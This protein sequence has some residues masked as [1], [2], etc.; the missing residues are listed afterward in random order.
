MLHTSRFVSDRNHR[1]TG[2][3]RPSVSGGGF[4]PASGC[5]GSDA[6][7]IFLYEYT[8]AVGD[9][10][11]EMSAPLRAE[12]W[13]MLRALFQDFQAIPGME[14]VTLL[15]PGRG[16]QRGA[17]PQAPGGGPYRDA[18]SRQRHRAINEEKSFRRLAG[19]A[20]YSLVIAPETDELLFNRCQ[21]V[22]EGGGTLLGPSAA[23]VQLTGDKLALGDRLRQHNIRTPSC[24]QQAS[25]EPPFPLPV[26]CKPR[27][28]AGSLHTTL[29]RT[30]EEWLEQALPEG[31]ERIV[32]PFVPGLAASVAFL[33]GPRQTV[34]LIP[35]TQELSEDGQFHYLGGRMPLAAPLAERA[36]RL[37]SQALECLE[38]EASSAEGEGWSVRGGP[39][40]TLHAPWVTHLKGYVGVDLILGAASDGSQDYVIEVNPRVTTSY[41]GLRALARSNLAESMLRIVQGEE[42]ALPPWKAGTIRF[43]PDGTINEEVSSTK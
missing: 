26:V 39:R 20:D 23:A 5:G 2:G 8:C 4:P 21:W 10:L 13:A 38:R 6:L 37:G 14:V 15:P 17:T 29:I 11:P 12:G 34:P 28:G 1:M 33:V 24:R 35:A 27:R 30:R 41:V 31:P 18:I 36:I 43:C 16:G 7:R 25:G 22:E 19:F 32:Q 3:D 9:D 40:C 42:I